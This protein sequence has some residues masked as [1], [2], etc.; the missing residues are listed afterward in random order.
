MKLTRRVILGLLLVLTSQLLRAQPIRVG[1]KHFTEGYLLSEMLALLI[2]DQGYVVERRF[3]LGGT[4]ICYSALKEN[5]IDIYPEYSGTISSEILKAT[6]NMT[7]PELRDTLEKSGFLV[8]DSYGFE[9]KYALVVTQ[10]LAAQSGV[11]KISHLKAHPSLRI[12]LSYEFLKRQ[13]GWEN[14]AKRYGLQQTAF[15]LEHGLAYGPLTK[16][17][18]DVTDAYSTD[19]EIPYYKLTLLE[20]DIGYFPQYQAISFCRNDLPAPV[21]AASEKL[22]GQISESEMQ[23]LN[24][25]VLF[26]NRPYAE[27]AEKFLVSKGLLKG[28]RNSSHLNELLART[29]EHVGLTFISLVLSILVAIPLSILV[30][31]KHRLSQVVIYA[32]GLLQTIPS[33][34]LLAILIPLTGIGA[35]PAVIALFLY[36]QLPILR[37]T[38]TGLRNID[39]ALKKVAD[40]LGMS[41]YQKLKFVEFPLAA[42]AILAGIRT[43]AVINVGTATLA[44]FIGAG[45]LGEFIV[46]GLALNNHSLILKGAIP[47][48]LLAIAIELLF[49]WMQRL[50][51]PKY[52]RSETA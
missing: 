6:R 13:D 48:A 31:R 24:A 3:H 14:L 30:Y 38:V 11:R 20:D 33:I 8:S 12:G 26:R 52:L 47:T 41:P 32:A 15:G 42:P 29:T 43:A 45:G 21:V 5:E 49:E 23:E 17:A 1:S 27:V 7:V 40:G 10:S 46:T 22:T 36:G 39:P 19:G 4:M 2:E 16:G 34:A 37:N 28:G 50:F 44:A 18:L 9:N 25:E 35:V 51:I